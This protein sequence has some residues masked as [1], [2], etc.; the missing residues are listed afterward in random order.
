MLY[1]RHCLPSAF[2]LSLNSLSVSQGLPQPLLLSP[3]SHCFLNPNPALSS[4]IIYLSLS[5]TNLTFS[6]LLVRH[7]VPFLKNSFPSFLCLILNVSAK[8][9]Y[10]W[11]TGTPWRY[12]GFR[13]RPLQYSEYCIK[14]ESHK[15]FFWFP[16]AYKN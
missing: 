13:Y 11:N 3:I 2:K 5:L 12:Y 15:F 7:A 4:F 9:D 1:N 6:H 10:F 8:Y 16:S 14:S